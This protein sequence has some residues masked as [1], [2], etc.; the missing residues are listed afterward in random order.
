MTPL[1]EVAVIEGI[2]ER[3]KNKVEKI[4]DAENTPYAYFEHLIAQIKFSQGNA[5]DALKLSKRAYEKIASEPNVSR[6]IYFMS[7]VHYSMALFYAMSAADK[8]FVLNNFGSIL[9]SLLNVYR[10]NKEV[11]QL[12]DNTMNF[13][14]E[15]SEKFVLDLKLYKMSAESHLG[16]VNQF[17]KIDELE[18]VPNIKS[19]GNFEQHIIYYNRRIVALQDIFAYEES[20]NLGCK[21]IKLI[22]CEK[23]F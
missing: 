3:F 14:G 6:L 22:R 9:K 4:I 17:S 21:V 16:K 19:G 15:G 8:E 20:L 12:I 5:D 10:K 23:N 2:A 13:I 7:D 1:F 18:S 11:L